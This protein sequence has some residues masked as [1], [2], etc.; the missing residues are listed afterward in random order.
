MAALARRARW[1][2]GHR[3]GAGLVGQPRRRLRLPGRRPRHHQ[4]DRARGPRLE[5]RR[6]RADGRGRGRGRADRATATT[7]SCAGLEAALRAARG[8]L[9][10]G[11]GWRIVDAQPHPAGARPRLVRGGD[12]RRRAGRQ[13]ARRRGPVDRRSCCGSRLRHRGPSRQRGGRAARRVRRRRRPGRT[14]SRRSGST[15]PRDLRAVLFIPDLRLADRRDARGAARVGAARGRGRQP[16]RGRGRGRRSRDRALRAARP[17]DRGPAPRAVSRDGL[18]A[19]PADGR[20]GP[21]RPGR[22]APA[23]RAP[24]RRSSPSPTRWPGITRIEAPSSRPPPTLDLPGRV[25]VVEPRNAGRPGRHAGLT[26][27]LRPA[28]GLGRDERQDLAPGRLARVGELG[29]LAVEEAVRR[30]RVGDEPMVDAGGRQGRVE[31]ATASGGMPASAPPNRP[32]TGALHLARD[33]DR[34]RARRCARSRTGEP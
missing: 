21:R 31:R 19:A 22:S 23:C 1:Q 15:A 20:G 30:A 2:P 18:P 10:E 9:P 13:R 28:G 11:V 5:P 16:G 7:V 26:G 34:D 24:A 12:R 4:P 14:A 29:G 6:D 33:V 27:P 25:L 3:R 8:E 32:R 17:A